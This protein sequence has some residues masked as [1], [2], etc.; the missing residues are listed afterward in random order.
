MESIT[1]LS[2]DAYFLSLLC[3]S[4][5]CQCLQWVTFTKWRSLRLI[6]QWWPAQVLNSSTVLQQGRR[7]SSASAPGTAATLYPSDGASVG[8]QTP[9]AFGPPGENMTPDAVATP[10]PWGIVC[11]ALLIQRSSDKSAVVRAKA[12][13]HLGSV[14]SCAVGAGAEEGAPLAFRRV[15]VSV[16]NALIVAHHY[17]KMHCYYY[18]ILTTLRY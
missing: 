8:G 18:L 16:I 9:M 17:C 14:I 10:A 7:V 15:C 11:L 6:S 5:T 12:L 3:F 1:D 4:R 13:A 2:P